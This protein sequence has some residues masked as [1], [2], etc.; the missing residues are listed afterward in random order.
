MPEGSLTRFWLSLGSNP[1]SNSNDTPEAV[2]FYQNQTESPG[3]VELSS[4]WDWI[5]PQQCSGRKLFW[6]YI[7]W[8]V[9]NELSFEN[10]ERVTFSPRAF[11]VIRVARSVNCCACTRRVPFGCNSLA[12]LH[13]RWQSSFIA[14]VNDWKEGLEIENLVNFFGICILKDFRALFSEC[15]CAFD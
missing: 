9:K 4:D 3:Q 11:E 2:F 5:T 8:I 15:L 14:S 12:K 10:E 6:H 1:L 7:P 13:C